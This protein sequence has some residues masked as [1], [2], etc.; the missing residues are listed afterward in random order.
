MK[1]SFNEMQYFLP[2]FK[3]F[4]RYEMYPETATIMWLGDIYSVL[5]KIWVWG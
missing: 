4:L 5:S 1:A 2:A 3:S